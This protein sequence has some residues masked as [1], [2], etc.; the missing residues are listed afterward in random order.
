MASE[1]LI[2][3]ATVV[4]GRDGPSGLEILMLKRNS[5]IAFGGAWV[6]PGG[7]VDPGDIGSSELDKAR[8]AAV[9]ESNEET[10]LRV[11]HTRM[12]VWSYWVPPRAREMVTSGS[13]KRRF[14]T[15]F[16]FAPAPADDYVTVDMGEI[17]EHRWLRPAD[18]IDLHRRAEIELIPPTWVTLHQLSAHSTI[19]SVTQA[20]SGSFDPPH[21]LTRPIP[22]DPIILTWEGD[23][24]YHDRSL[25]DSP[26]SR[27]RLTMSSGNWIYERRQ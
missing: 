16:F 20:A 14:S 11:D 13:K 3:A 1:E 6:F 26:G 19:E 9:R 24:A 8:S 15:W 23:V 22:G 4:L 10:G 17:H 18:A 12:H 25:R 5:Q 2:P 27:N 21:F 7:R